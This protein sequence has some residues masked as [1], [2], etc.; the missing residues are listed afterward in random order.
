M[1]K[2][3]AAKRRRAR[4]RSPAID[5]ARVARI[6][7]IVRAWNGAL[8]W[9]ALCRQV[10][11]ETGNLYSRQALNN[12]TEIKAAYAAYRETRGHHKVAK[13]L[14]STQQRILELEQKVIELEAVRDVLLEKFA[15]WA[16]NASTRNLDEAFLD[17]PLRPINRSENL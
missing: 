6:V 2:R 5:A 3:L 12:F 8:T 7:D 9:E 4:R 17:Q 14:S 11:T 15:R 16:I 1:T 13:P 10:A